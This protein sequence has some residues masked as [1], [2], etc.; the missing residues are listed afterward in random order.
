MGYISYNPNPERKLV[1]DCVIRAIAKTTN[2]DWEDV[3]VGVCVQGMSMHDMPSSNSVWGRYLTERGFN[4]H[5][6]N[7]IC[8]PC[9]TV[10][11]FCDANPHLVG[12]LG[13]GTHVVAIEHGDYF[14]TWDSGDEIPISFWT[15]EG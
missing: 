11:D 6:V 10:R 4:V 2:R 3:Y 14:D 8:P 12:I 1:G 7:D 13:T 9:N 5:A 15:K